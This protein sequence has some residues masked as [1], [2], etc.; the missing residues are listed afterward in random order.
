MSDYFLQKSDYI[1]LRSLNIGYTFTK[2]L[3]GDM[4]PLDSFRVYFQGQNLYTWTNYEGDP[5]VAIGSGEGNTAVPNSYSLYTYPS[6][7]TFTVG[8]Q[9]NF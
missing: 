2:K 6:Q 7:K 8:L 1:R 3:L 4:I 5:E 9:L